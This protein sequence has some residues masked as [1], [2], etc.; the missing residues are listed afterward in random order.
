MTRNR[1]SRGQKREIK[2]SLLT[3]MLVMFFAALVVCIGLTIF[4]FSIMGKAVY[5]KL[6]ANDL[7]PKA[8]DLADEAAAYLSGEHNEDTLRFIMRSSDADVVMLDTNKEPMVMIDSGADEPLPLPEG[9]PEGEGRPDDKPDG[10]PGGDIT[11]G[12]DPKGDRDRGAKI[13]A[14]QIEACKALYDEV[15]DE[16]ADEFIKYDKNLGA[17]AAVPILGENKE[18]FGALFLIKPLDNISERSKTLVIVLALAAVISFILML[19]PIFLMTRWLNSPLKKLN[20]AAKDFSSGDYSGRV[21]SHGSQ[22]LRQLGDTFNLLAENLEKNIGDLTYERNRLRAILDGLGEGIV[23]FDGKG[24]LIQYNSSAAW[25]LGADPDADISDLPLFGR[26]KE[27]AGRVIGEGEGMADVID[28][29]DRF[30]KVSVA[31]I[32][33][34]EGQAAGAVALLLDITE[35]ERLEQTRRDYVANVSHEL[36]TPLASIRGI[37]DMLNDDLVKSEEDKHR[38]YGYILKESIRLSTLINDLLELSRLQS[39]GVAL[40]MRRV[41]LYE[42]ILDVADR[43]TASASDRNM[44]IELAVEEGVYYA[45]SNPDR[46]E[47]IMVSLMD[48][49]V[50]HGTQG[51]VVTAGLID[52]GEKWE[53]YVENPAEIEQKDIDHLFERFY[54]ADTAHTGE[55]TGLGLAITEEILRLMGETISVRCENGIIRFNFTVSKYVK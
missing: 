3:S 21:E 27:L 4:L 31:P 46:L 43:M 1:K 20:A 16:H 18:I 2:I 30:I 11:P 35:A 15:V 8:V 19:V 6:L 22:E 28:C 39:G 10:K 48:N 54:K 25:L 44:S 36:R 24:E 47:Q 23:G 49:A 9:R 7:A 38:Y 12:G 42:L 34:S 26:V 41:E 29:S 17:V 5:A 40:S 55:G 52:S 53:I 51:G 37:A 32:D 14:E 33:V 13:S 50:K 45:N